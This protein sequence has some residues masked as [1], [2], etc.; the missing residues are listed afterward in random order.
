[1]S[2]IADVMD[3][4]AE[5]LESELQPQTDIKL[6]IQPRAFLAAET[7]RIDMIV[8][9]S[10]ALE[11]GKMGYGELA[12]VIPITIRVVVSIADQDAGENLLLAFMDDEDPLSIIKAIDSDHTL[13]GTAEDVSWDQESFPWL[14]YTDFTDING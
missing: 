6:N 10:T 13:G 5:Q 3:A 2:T 8:T 7:P 11:A 14:G 9:S 12:D 4:L 1:M